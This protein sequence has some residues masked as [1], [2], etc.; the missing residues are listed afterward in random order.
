[1]DAHQGK[2]MVGHYQVIAIVASAGGHAAISAVLRGLPQLF[3]VP[4][5]VVQHLGAEATG[6]VEL[7]R[8]QTSI[9]VEAIEDHSFISPGTILVAPPRVFVKLMP[10]GSC[11]LSPCPRGALDKPLDYFLNSVARSFGPHAIG[12]VLTGMGDDG[13]L[14]ARHL[15]DARGQVLVQT[16]GSAEH[17]D[18][19]R[20]AIKAGA[21]NLVVPL[22]N[23]GQVITEIVEGTPRPKARS[24][25][26]AVSRAF[27]DRGEV[28]AFAKEL[29]WALTSLGPILNW[30]PTLQLSVR[31][32]M[33]SLFPTAI[34]WGSE[35]TQIYNDRWIAFLG[36]SKHPKALGQRAHDTWG[37]IWHI[38]GPMVD[39][40]RSSGGPIGEENFPLYL[41]RDGMLEEVFTTL[42]LAPI[43]DPGTGKIVGIHHTASITT[44][45]VV[46]ERRLRALRELAS[47][48]AGVATPREVCEHAAA[49]L[50]SDPA[51]LPF[52]LIY[53]IDPVREQGSL[54]GAAGLEAG[55]A[56][57]PRL[58]N[59]G[60]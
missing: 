36:T 11:A 52:V 8:R 31:T 23:L 55:V 10:D 33:D 60:T 5:L 27:G 37:E 13:A 3:S 47:K 45:T 43:R 22:A 9:P 15:H 51:D 24:E 54:A 40:V 28:A 19:P 38:L 57:A 42:A 16:E 17:P 2:T 26:D 39:R 4:I 41:S 6:A 7:Y 18:M 58:A 46:A 35:L 32:V 49:A 25:L 29:D 30:S 56:A 34:W 59:L 21:A 12:V 48:T 50:V 1:M 53:Q 14:G 44:T 20:A